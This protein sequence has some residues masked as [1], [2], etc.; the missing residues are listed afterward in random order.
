MTYTSLPSASLCSSPD[1]LI[2]IPSKGVCVS[3]WICQGP[4]RVSVSVFY[5]IAH[6]AGGPAEQRT[7]ASSQVQ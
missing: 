5:W 4:N 1:V 3:G 7:I 2:S 6:C